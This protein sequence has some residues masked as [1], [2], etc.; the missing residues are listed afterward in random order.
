MLEGQS[1]PSLTAECPAFHW[2]EREIREQT[3]IVPEGHPWLKPI[4]FENGAA[5]GV[6]EYFPLEGKAA[7]E[8]AVGPVHAGVIEPGHFRFQC[9]GE[10]VQFLEIELG[11]QHRGL[12]HLLT[13][14]PETRTPHWIETAAGDSSVAAACVYGTLLR[15]MAE[16]LPPEP[17]EAPLWR[18]VM[19]ELERIANHVG[20][21]GALA[22][23]VAFLPTASYCGR[24]R[25]DYLNLTASLCGNRFGRSLWTP[26]GAA[27]A[28]PAAAA[29]TVRSRIDELEKQ[30]NNALELMFDAPSVLDRFENTGSVSRE[31]ASALGLVGAAARA[32]GCKMDARRDFPLPET[33][34]LTEIPT[35]IRGDVFD[36]ADIRRK[37]IAISHSRIRMLLE[38]IREDLPAAEESWKAPA[39]QSLRIGA[40]VTESWRGELWHVA[41]TD[42]KGKFQ[43]Y[44]IVDPSFHN[45]AGLAMALRGAQISDFPICHKSFNLSYCGHDL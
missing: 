2:F 21:L 12:D 10:Q 42:E 24:I 35:G 40:A 19:L 38:K 41:L 1:Y 39:L 43:R 32:C 18:A 37:E 14:G 25:G 36:R 28:I 9:L 6:T 30:L 22:G 20:D 44:K 3:G 31:D 23:D 45:W 27:L 4:R 33:D 11:Y 16:N 13:G 26:R 17:P 29:A 8:V 5:P 34:L 15:S 7:H